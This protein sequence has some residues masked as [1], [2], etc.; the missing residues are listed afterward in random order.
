MLQAAILTESSLK[1]TSIS[2]SQGT[3]DGLGFSRPLGTMETNYKTGF[4]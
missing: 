2:S 3:E 4:Q 1:M